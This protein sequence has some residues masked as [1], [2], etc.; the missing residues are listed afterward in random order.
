M[1]TKIELLKFVPRAKPALID[2]V[3]DNWPDAEG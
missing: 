2:A 1:V 3:V